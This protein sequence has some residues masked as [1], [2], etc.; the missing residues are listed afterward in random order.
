VLAA[1]HCDLA[2]AV[3]A[4]SFR[5]DLY[6][7]LRVI[8]LRVPPLRERPE[9]I[10]PLAESFLAAA[11]HRLGRPTLP[12]GPA[13]ALGLCR[14]A[15]P[16][17]VRELEHAMERAAALAAG[18]CVE[19]CDLPDDLHDHPS[20]ATPAAT[21]TLQQLEHAAILAALA[22]HG[23][24]QSAAAAELGISASTLYRRLRSYGH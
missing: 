11:A 4:G 14:H 3:A 2:A 23:G 20:H 5:R 1:T 17:N 13:A 19:P 8:E 18:P 9:D 7:R 10:L 21:G 24:Q 15:W 6:Y 22:R 16:G 12:I